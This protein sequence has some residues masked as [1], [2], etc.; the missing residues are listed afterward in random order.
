M[1]ARRAQP[2]T[3]RRY[4]KLFKEVMYWKFRFMSASRGLVKWQLAVRAMKIIAENTTQ[5]RQNMAMADADRS[6]EIWQL[7]GD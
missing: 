6:E 3:R 1:Y 7:P 5:E 2:P 4:K